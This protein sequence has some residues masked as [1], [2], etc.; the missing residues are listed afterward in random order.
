MGWNTLDVSKDARVLSAVEPGD[1]AYFVHSYYVDP[2]RAGG[3]G[4]D[5]VRGDVLQR[6]SS[7]TTSSASSSTR[8]SP[9]N[10]GRRVLERYFESSL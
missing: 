10:V 5:D 6:A 2:D 3:R 9:A 1:M 8:R 7:R 4:D